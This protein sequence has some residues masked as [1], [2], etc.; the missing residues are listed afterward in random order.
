MKTKSENLVTTNKELKKANE[1]FELMGKAAND[2]LWDLNLETGLA[3]ANE[4]HQQMYGLTLAD[5]VP[6]Y[7][8]WKHRIH[9]EDR[10]RTVKTFEESVSSGSS[11]CTTEYRFNTERTGYIHI[12]GR[13]LIERNSQGKPVRYI[14]SMMDISDRIKKE[15][16][17]VRSENHLRVILDTSPTCIKLINKS[18]A[19]EAMNPSGLALIEADSFEQVKGKSLL[20]IID[21]PYRKAFEQLNKNVFKG[22]SGMLEFEITGLKGSRHWL[23]TH[24]VPL[25]DAEG[26]IIFLLGTTLDITE[27]K[28]TEKEILRAIERY[29]LLAKATSDTIWDW[30]I[31]NDMMLYNEGIVHMFGYEKLKVENI[32]DWWKNKI[33]PNDLEIVLEAISAAFK[34]QSSNLQLEYRFRCADQSYKYIY[35]RAF[36]IYDENNMPCKILGAMQDI[37]KLKENEISLNK[38]NKN[39]Q[40]QT[41]E[42]TTLNEELEVQNRVLHEIA[43]TQSHIVRAPLARMLGIVNVIKDIKVGTPEFEDWVNHFIASGNELDTIIKDI[44]NK[45]I[46]KKQDKL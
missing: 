12:Y 1:R 37:S 27:R 32:S 7:E 10:E 19:L 31:S 15:E 17:L 13:I 11:F 14:G 23:E 22:K 25:K 21:K 40:K 6:N 26:N 20:G 35:D 43:W 46:I 5:P 42:L 39:L 44:V 33:H 30:D 3:W 29:E 4:V 2:G 16:E 28:K 24:A 41:K 45:T 36:I 34:K 9:P 8:E 38:L 18:G